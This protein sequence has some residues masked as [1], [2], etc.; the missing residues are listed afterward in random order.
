MRHDRGSGKI[1]REISRQQ[2]QQQ[3]QRRLAAADDN[4][5]MTDVSRRSRHSAIINRHNSDY[6]GGSVP[7]SPC[8]LYFPIPV[9]PYSIIFVLL[10]IE[11]LL[12]GGIETV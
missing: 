12:K 9:R 7:S 4:V 1:I 5:A 6:F 2:Q 8:P 10:S 11:N 3:Q